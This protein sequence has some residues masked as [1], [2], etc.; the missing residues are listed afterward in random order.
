MIYFFHTER[1]F[2]MQETWK[3]IEE[4]EGI[5]EV[6]TL[7]NVR[8]KISGI[9]KLPH[10]NGHGYKS[11]SL[12][13]N[14]HYKT[15]YV[16]RL[17]ATAFI[18]NPDKKPEVHHI[19]SDRSNNKL[20][21]LQWVTSKENNNFPEHIKAMQSNENWAKQRQ[22]SM[23]KAR[24]KAIVINSYRARFIKNGIALEFESL[25]E[26]A[27]KLGLDKGGATRVANG[28]QAHTHG[29]VIE[30]VGK[31]IKDT[32]SEKSSLIKSGKITAEYYNETKNSKKTQF[33]KDGVSQAFKSLTEGAK[34]LGLEKT[35]AAKV[36]NGKY[37]QTKGY[38][39]EY[40]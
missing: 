40:I 21:N 8:N 38:Y 24:D 13:Q 3:D 1:S 39:V 9:M 5:Y 26:G 12:S 20:D 32:K 23:A 30:Y 18:D 7:G 25:A 22:K 15:R 27:R 28:K 2:F 29:Y 37:K 11:V 16:H 10:D 6:S 17:V 34:Q 4:Y 36:A 19:D 33:T 35:T 31:E 14:G